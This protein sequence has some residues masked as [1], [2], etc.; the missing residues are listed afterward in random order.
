MER[1]VIPKIA[2]QS[3]K[4][5]ETGHNVFILTAIAIAIAPSIAITKRATSD[6]Q[7]Q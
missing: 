7:N 1:S 4:S 2:Y 3:I 5:L 6:A